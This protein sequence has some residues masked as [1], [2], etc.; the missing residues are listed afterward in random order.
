VE[1]IREKKLK[2]SLPVYRNVHSTIFEKEAQRNFPQTDR[3]FLSDYFNL[4]LHK[5]FKMLRIVE[6]KGREEI[7]V[8][9][10]TNH[11][12]TNPVE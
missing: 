7:T 12:K 1:K 3:N 4:T 2:I 9:L 10:P 8:S 11:L 5:G 6:S